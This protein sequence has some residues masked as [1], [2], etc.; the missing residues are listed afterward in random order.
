VEFQ[1]EKKVLLAEK[2][3]L[4]LQQSFHELRYHDTYDV[5]LEH[6]LTVA[7]VIIAFSDS[8]RNLRLY[9]DNRLRWREQPV[10][11]RTYSNLR[12]PYQFQ[13]CTSRDLII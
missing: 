7:R 3:S 12:S 8:L 10:V 9:V 2:Y 1:R 4:V 5:V 13:I 6:P 11:S